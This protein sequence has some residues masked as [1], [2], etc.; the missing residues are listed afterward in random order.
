M[1]YQ[2]TQIVMSWMKINKKSLIKGG[3]GLIDYMSS[4]SSSS[5]FEFEFVYSL[6]SMHAV[7]QY[8]LKFIDMLI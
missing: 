8:C 6:M 3:D 5:S 4:S 7:L 2:A 1:Y